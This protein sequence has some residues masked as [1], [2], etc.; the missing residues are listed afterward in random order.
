MADTKITPEFKDMFVSL[1]QDI[2]NITVVCKLAGIDPSN[3]SRARQNDPEFDKAV[4]EAREFGY[5]M[6]EEEARRRAVDGVLEPVFY[7]GE[8]IGNIRRYSDQLLSQLLKAYKPKKFNPGVKLGIG[9]GEKT[10]LTLILDGDG[11]GN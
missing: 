4:L 5:D 2:P 9:E 7:K 6:V 11:N 8:E 3:I 10:T 1:L